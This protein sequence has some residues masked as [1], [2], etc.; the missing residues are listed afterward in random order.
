V[1]KRFVDFLDGPRA[2]LFNEWLRVREGSYRKPLDPVR[3]DRAYRHYVHRCER[4]GTT[5]L[6]W[7]RALAKW[8]EAH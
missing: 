7:D 1:W 5:P 3:V 4:L 8:I 6:P 2:A